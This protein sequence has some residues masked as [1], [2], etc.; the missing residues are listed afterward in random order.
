MLRI[1]ILNAEISHNPEN[2]EY[3][4]FIYAKREDQTIETKYRLGLG[5]LIGNTLQYELPNKCLLYLS[6]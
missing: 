4:S 3:I 2:V 1:T 5:R 6:I